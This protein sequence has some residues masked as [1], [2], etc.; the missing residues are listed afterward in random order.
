MS[1][2]DG[3]FRERAHCTCCEPPRPVQRDIPYIVE[4]GSLGH[5]EHPDW[6]SNEEWGH[7]DTGHYA[8]MAHIHVG[9][10]STDCD[11]RTTSGRTVRIPDYRDCDNVH[12]LWQTVARFTLPTGHWQSASIE[13]EEGLIRWSERTDE[14]GTSGEM[15][16]CSSPNCAHDGRH[17]QDHAAEAMGY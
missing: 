3:T 14:G 1:G 9:Q 6:D 7:D 15:R 17:F 5:C 4:D 10:S 8:E 12:D 11:G 13:V 16:L 2:F